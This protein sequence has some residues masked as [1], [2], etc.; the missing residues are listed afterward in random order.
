MKAIYNERSWV[1]DIISEANLFLVGTDR[2]ICRFGGENTLKSNSGN[3]FPDVLIYGEGTTGIILQGW[4]LKMPDTPIT[5]STLIENAKQ[6]ANIIRTNSFLIWNV[7][8]AILYIKENGDFVPKKSWNDLTFIRNREEVETN[9]K[10]WIALLKKIINDLNEYLKKGAIK[11]ITILDTFS[12]EQI[13]DLILKNN[14]SVAS[15]LAKKAAHNA[16]FDSEINLWWSSVKNEYINELEPW[17]VLGRIILTNWINKFI[18]ANILKNYCSSAS[19]VECITNNTEVEHAYSIFEEISKKCDFWSVFKSFIGEIYITE[20]AWSEL[21]QFNKFLLDLRLEEID[22]ELTKQIIQKTVQVSKRKMAGQYVTPKF[23]AELLLRII[24]KDKYLIIYDPFCGTGTIPKTAYDIKL[25][26][27]QDRKEALE[28]VWA[29]DKFSFLL[30]IAVLSFSDPQNIG[31]LL[32]IFRM[33]ALELKDREAIELQN[34]CNEYLISKTLP[35]FHYIASN[36]PFVQKEDIEKA[37]PGVKDINYWL[38]ESIGE[39]ISGNS[40][41]YAYLPFYL[42]HILS[43]NGRLGIITSNSW[44]GTIWGRLFRQIL[45]K[46]FHIEKIIISGNKKWFEETQVSTSFI[47]LNKRSKIDFLKNDEE[48]AYITVLLP[49]EELKKEETIR[50]VSSSIILNQNNG[51]IATNVYTNKEIDEFEKCGMSGNA[52][53]A[54]IK[55][56]MDIKDKLVKT[57]ELFRVFRGERRG[58]DKMFFP[59]EAHGIENAYIKSVLKSSRSIE[60]LVAEANDVAFCCSNSIDELQTLGH[61]GALSWIARFETE[62]NDVGE[63]LPESLKRAGMYWYEMKE[64]SMADLISLINYDKKLYVAKM[65]EKSF[66]N[67]RLIGFNPHND[68]VDIELCHALLNSI[69]SLFYIEALG[70]GRGLGAL[71]LNTGKIKKDFFMLNPDLLNEKQKIAIKEKFSQLLKRRVLPIEEELNKKDRIDFDNEVLK[72]YNILRYKDKIFNSLMHLYR[73]R[74]SVR[75]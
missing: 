28:T 55:W 11:T 59:N 27:G 35:E 1:I 71:D 68:G 19:K 39:K 26:Y 7:T 52:L 64:S 43:L 51:Y 5:D 18:F 9:K 10:K 40:D 38:Q 23:L 70:F 47:I 21:I 69:I 12:G 62:Y 42:W 66:I 2:A 67:Q 72:S 4:E 8:T 49:P 73:T 58:W 46:Y 29:S 32:N 56:I 48:T 41:L 6:K 31:E 57:S 36:L 20:K 33:D 17:P 34:P 44:L 60:G 15:N 22:Q 54:N 53:F 16:T 14:D 3:L 30:Q 25:E 13:V 74:I 65:R 50:N 37:N 45:K 61:R 75:Q 24:M 63:P